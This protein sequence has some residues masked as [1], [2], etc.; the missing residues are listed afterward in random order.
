MKSKIQRGFTVIE[1]LVSLGIIIVLS[2]VIITTFIQFKKNQ[3]LSKDT[4]TVVEVLSQARNQTLSSKNSSA[5]GVHFASN[6]IT[7]FTGN[8]YSVSD[9]ANQ[10]FNLNSTDTVLTISLTGSGTD[11]VFNRLTGETSQD[12]TV[13]ISSPGLSQSKTVTIYKTGVIESQ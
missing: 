9:P 4:E 5:Y 3:A 1:L 8:A 10:D 2:A 6:K 12:G 11:V 7:L 13:I